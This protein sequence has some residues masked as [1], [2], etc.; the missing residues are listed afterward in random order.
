[1]FKSR[2]CVHTILVC[3]L[4]LQ[5]SLLLVLSL[6]QHGGGVGAKSIGL[7]NRRL[8]SIGS[9]SSSPSSSSLKQQRHAK[10]NAASTNSDSSS[11]TTQ[12]KQTHKK[13]ADADCK[14]PAFL[15]QNSDYYNQ[16]TREINLKMFFQLWFKIRSQMSLRYDTE[17]LDALVVEAPYTF[18]FDELDMIYFSMESYVRCLY[19]ASASASE[20]ASSS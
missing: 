3:S 4:V 8:S 10:A 18:K 19:E 7:K 9:A 6:Q 13:E 12:K 17:D 14:L 5:L 2:A 15:K 1:M 11:E 20:S 16:R